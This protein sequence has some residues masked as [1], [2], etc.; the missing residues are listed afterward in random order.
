MQN[1]LH[2]S[3]RFAFKNNMELRHSNRVVHIKIWFNTITLST[4]VREKYCLICITF[5]QDALS[6]HDISNSYILILRKYLIEIV[7]D[8]TRFRVICINKQ[9]LHTVHMIT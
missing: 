1:A 9:I 3:L 4:I 8:R 6:P 2:R 5:V 7:N